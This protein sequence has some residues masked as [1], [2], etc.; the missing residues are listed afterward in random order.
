MAPLV[1]CTRGS[2]GKFQIRGVVVFNESQLNRSIDAASHSIFEAEVSDRQHGMINGR[3]ARRKNHCDKDNVEANC[4]AKEH[5]SGH[6]KTED[7]CESQVIKLPALQKS[8]RQSG[9]FI[10]LKERP[11][12]SGPAITDNSV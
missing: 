5:I 4:S 6:G 12:T 11:G 3:N 2:D 8:S 9:K 10:G 1:R 7:K